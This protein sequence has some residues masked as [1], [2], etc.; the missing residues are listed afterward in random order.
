MP[1]ARANLLAARMLRL[2]DYRY[3]VVAEWVLAI[4]ETF[5]AINPEDLRATLNGERRRVRFS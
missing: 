1:I 2:P 4:A 5:E 3:D